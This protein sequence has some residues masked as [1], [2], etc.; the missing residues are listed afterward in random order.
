MDRSSFAG[1]DLPI[2]L[3]AAKVVES[4]IVAS[5]Q[6][7]LQ[8]LDPP[9]VALAFDHVPSIDGIAPAL[10]SRAEGIRRDSSH[11]FRL[12]ACVKTEIFRMRPHIGAVVVHKDGHVTDDADSPLCAITV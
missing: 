5:T 11:D 9:V 8:A 10:P 3:E 4:Q 6:R 7:P 1:W 12:Q 2:L